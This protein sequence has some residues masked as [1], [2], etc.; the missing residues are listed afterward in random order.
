LFLKRQPAVFQLSAEQE[1]D[2]ETKRKLL[3]CYS[4]SLRD[5]S[6]LPYSETF[7]MFFD[8]AKSFSNKVYNQQF[9]GTLRSVRGLFSL[10]VN[11]ENKE[12]RVL[13]FDQ[14]LYDFSQKQPFSPYHEELD[15]QTLGFK[16]DLVIKTDLVT[17]PLYAGWDERVRKFVITNKLLSRKFAG[18]QVNNNPEVGK[19]SRKIKFTTWPLSAQQIEQRSGYV[20]LYDTLDENEKALYGQVVPF[21]TLPANVNRYR[22]PDLTKPGDSEQFSD[23]FESLAPKRGGFVWPG[24]SKIRLPLK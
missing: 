19:Q 10:T 20:T 12:N 11:N 1:A 18:Y 9:K 21:D 4:D 17:K 3:E 5:Y 24:T 13:K 14:P 22:Q 8:G 15:N 23:R 7:E 16:N 6:N 2:L